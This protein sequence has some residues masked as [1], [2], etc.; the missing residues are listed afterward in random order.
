[1]ASKNKT[2]KNETMLFIVGSLLLI[3]SFLLFHY[4]KILEVASNLKSAIETE[5]YKEN[6]KQEFNNSNNISV[7]VS[8]DYL[9]RDQKEEEL[10]ENNYTPNYIAFL[11]INKINLKQGLMPINSPYNNV[12]YHVQILNISDMPDVINGNFILAGHSGTSNIA[13]FK[14]LYKLSLSDLA[15]VYYNSHVYTYKIVNIYK[16][17]KDGSVN[18]YR[19]TN[20]TTLTLITCTKN[21][22]E[23]QTIYI[24]ELIGVETY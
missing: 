23:H 11:E 10:E 18:I 12:N 16:E 14:N 9:E 4:E 5:I 22:K 21:D 24:L 6:T 13:Y 1:M 8:V 15:K 19:D 2:N 7:N 17:D 3:I 20:K